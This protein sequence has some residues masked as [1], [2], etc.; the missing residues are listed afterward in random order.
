MSDIVKADGEEQ[1]R[2]LVNDMRL[3]GLVA[4]LNNVNNI[5]ADLHDDLMNMV[6]SVL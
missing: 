3:A 6:V 5:P 2:S 4:R 1:L